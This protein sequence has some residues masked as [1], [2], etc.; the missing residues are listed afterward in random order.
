[1][2]SFKTCSQD[3]YSPCPTPQAAA[4]AVTCHAVMTDKTTARLHS[5]IGQSQVQRQLHT[6]RANG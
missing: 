3:Q 6:S 4:I 5:P 1:M 2:M